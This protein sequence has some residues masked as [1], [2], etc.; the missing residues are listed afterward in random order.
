MDRP[1]VRARSALVALVAL[2]ALAPATARADGAFPDSLQIFAPRDAPERI[3]LATN[4][5]LVTT[6]DGGATWDLV[7][8]NA[9]AFGAYL[10][11][12]GAAPADRLYAV[13]FEVPVV[14]SS[15]T[16]CDFSVASFDPSVD[17]GRDVFPDPTDPL[18][19]LA[20]D[21]PAIDS[22]RSHLFESRDGGVSFA[23][24]T[25]TAPDGARLTGVEIAASDPRFVYLTMS[26]AP[27]VVPRLV[28]SIDGG[29][30]FETIDLSSDLGERIPYLG[31]VDP[32]DPR[33]LFLRLI[34]MRSDALALSEDGGT[35]FEIVLDEADQ[36]SALLILPGGTVLVG[37]VYGGG[38]HLSTDGGRTFEDWPSPIH[39][40]ALAARG[41]Q[42]YA[43]ADDAADGFAL[44]VSDDLGQSWRP[45]LHF[46]DIRG[47]KPCVEAA[48]ADAFDMLLAR[49]TGPPVG[50]IDLPVPRDRGC[51]CT[52]V[53]A[54]Q[55]GA[56][57]LIAMAAL[58]GMV[59]RR[60]SRR[61][62]A[63]LTAG[64]GG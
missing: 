6:E 23:G 58:L 41:G 2:V 59:R 15:S 49:L 34:G 38:G 5:G 20:L 19:V 4:F 33:R 10:Y 3:V 64:S 31:A 29:E 26:S 50:G 18:H 56:G 40:R 25:F 14:S 57:G 43:A 55:E 51:G 48:C 9:V 22:E 13:G 44:G 27:M 8:E 32:E 24:P 36:L 42:L 61:G 45:L 17:Y 7:C 12:M 21:L 54:A 47:P 53:E 63:K 37:D 62:R 35:S 30:T 11:Q 60:R 16:A 52:G 1:A 28:R 46:A 39:V